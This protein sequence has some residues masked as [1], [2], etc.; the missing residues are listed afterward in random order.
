MDADIICGLRIVLNEYN[1][2]VKVF[3]IVREIHKQF[4]ELPIRIRL[5]ANRSCKGRNYSASITPEIA[6]L[7]V[8]DIGISDHVSNIM[9]E[10]LHE[11]LKRISDLHPLLMPLQCPS[12]LQ[13]KIAFT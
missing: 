10:H 12:L 6:T 1:E 2:I 5:L 13:Y 11:G 8:G 9:V 4:T 3:Q 7:I